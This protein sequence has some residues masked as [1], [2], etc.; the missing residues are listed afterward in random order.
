MIPNVLATRYA[1]AEMTRIWSAEHKVVL[2]RRL[3]IAVLR[4]QRDLGLDVPES[5]IEAYEQ[6][7]DKVGNK[8]E[9]NED[10]VLMELAAAPARRSAAVGAGARGVHKAGMSLLR[11]DRLTGRPADLDPAVA[12]LGPKY[13]VLWTSD[14]AGLDL[15]LEGVDDHVPRA[16]PCLCCGRRNA[17]LGR[18]PVRS[19]N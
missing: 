3:W 12:F 6:V 11:T 15:D 1:S 8:L 4:A 2:E 13:F 9:P 14:G 19:K 17:L 10:G 18:V 16:V 7:V 5:V